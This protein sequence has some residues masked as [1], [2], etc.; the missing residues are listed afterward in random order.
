MTSEGESLLQSRIP[1]PNPEWLSQVREDIIE[2]DLPIIDPHHHLWDMKG[3][4][5]LLDNLLADLG[6]GHNIVA[7]VFLECAAMYRSD[8]PIHMRP[9]GETEFVNGIAAMAASGKYGKTKI[10]AGI[11]GFADLTLGAS[12]AEVLEAQIAAGNGR[13]KGTRYG[14]GYDP[15][16]EINN[17]HTNPPP[18]IYN[19]T[20][21][22]EGFSKLKDYDLSFEAWLY[23][24]QISDVCSLAD[25]FPDQRIVLNHF[26]GPMGI[27]PYMGKTEAVFSDWKKSIKDLSKRP[28]VYAKLGGLGMVING[29]KF[30]ERSA[31]P[32]SEAL[33][34]LWRPYFEETIQAF[35]V[36]RCMFESNFPVDKVTSTYAVYWNLFKRIASGATASDKKYLFHDTAKTFYN[37]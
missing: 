31:P 33:A 11:V 25:A 34:G 9:I 26:G 1:S 23:H 28:N 32:S 7:T 5:Y 19:N 24:T 16:P 10:C 8:G 3:N 6:S 13:F 27:G 17:S 4:R 2:P 22:R 21:F 20:K 15:S 30:E 29:Y 35:G 37:L 18:G 14:A 36:Q 12:V